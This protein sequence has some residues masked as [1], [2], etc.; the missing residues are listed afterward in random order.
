MRFAMF[1]PL[2]FGSIQR[3]ARFLGGMFAQSQLG[4]GCFAEWRLRKKGM[5]AGLRGINIADTLNF[6]LVQTLTL[7][8]GH[9]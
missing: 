2:T 7:D 4:R 1:S 5:Q 9:T 3:C 6:D 8:T